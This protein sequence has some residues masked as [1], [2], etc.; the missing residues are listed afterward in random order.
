ME[1]QE[2]KQKAREI[3]VKVDEQLGSVSKAAR[4]C[5]IAKIPFFYSPAFFY[6]QNYLENWQL[7]NIQVFVLTKLY[8]IYRTI[9]TDTTS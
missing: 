6:N 7:N 1:K 8:R 4:H 3:W 2:Q 9:T 5:G